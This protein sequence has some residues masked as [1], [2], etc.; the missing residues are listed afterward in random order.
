MCKRSNRLAADKQTNA[1]D[2]QTEVAEKLVS[3]LYERIPPALNALAPL[4]HSPP[5]FSPLSSSTA[6][7]LE[8]CPPKTRQGNL[9]SLMIL[10]GQTM[11]PLNSTLTPRQ[12]APF[13]LQA[14]NLLFQKISTCMRL[15]AY[16][17]RPLNGRL[18]CKGI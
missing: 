12:I 9:V 4:W 15:G 1:T 5:N 8:R 6:T 11:I 7:E 14:M 10:H 17:S 3:A 16:A 13:Y 2:Q 18:K